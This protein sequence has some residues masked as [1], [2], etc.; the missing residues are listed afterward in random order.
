[1]IKTH[2]ENEPCIE[3]LVSGLEKAVITEN[4]LIGRYDYALHPGTSD[5]A[6][7]RIQWPTHSSTGKGTKPRYP[8]YRI[9]LIG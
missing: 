9:I 1:M 6:D 3:Q 2:P 5:V 8:N 4:G 7:E